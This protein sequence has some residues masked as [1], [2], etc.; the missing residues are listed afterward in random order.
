MKK[1][2]IIVFVFVLG[3]TTAIAQPGQGQRDFNPEEMAKRQTERL[4]EELDLSADQE[5]KVYEINLESGKK[6]MEIRNASQNGGSDSVREKMGEIREQ[7]N[8]KMKEVLTESQW[9]LYEKYLE[10]RRER[11][12]N[13]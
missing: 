1:I 6:M 11:R 13:R 3:L 8:E 5:K 12:G 4:D 7:Q 10:E 2:G 9:K